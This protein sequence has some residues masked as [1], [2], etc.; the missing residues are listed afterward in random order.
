MVLSATLSATS[1]ATAHATPIYAL[2]RCGV[3]DRLTVGTDAPGT[4]IDPLSDAGSYILKYLNLSD[5]SLTKLVTDQSALSRAVINILIAPKHGKLIWNPNTGPNI[6]AAEKSWYYY[7]SNKGYSGEDAFVMQVEM[8]GL[9]IYI[10]YTIEVPASDENPSGLCQLGEEW[11]ISQVDVVD[12]SGTTLASTTFAPNAPF[13]PTSPLAYL[14]NVTL[15]LPNADSGISK[16]GKT[17]VRVEWHLLKPQ[18][19][20]LTSKKGWLE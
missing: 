12:T 15:N 10:H 14:A 20:D 13:L 17:G 6:S 1:T 11:K 8:Y 18:P 3:A 7:V 5:S 2:G 19:T 16:T 9:K 4:E